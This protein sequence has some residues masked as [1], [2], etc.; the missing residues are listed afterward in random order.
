[1]ADV[2]VFSLVDWFAMSLI[3]GAS[4]TAFTVCV[5]VYF[6]LKLPSLTLTVMVAVPL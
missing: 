1:M 4:F 6:A 5:N 2:A 3:V